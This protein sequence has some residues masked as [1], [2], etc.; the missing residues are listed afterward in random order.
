M[1]FAFNFNFIVA[2]FLREVDFGGI[3]D[4]S[5]AY[6]YKLI[7]E[8]MLKTNEYSVG[9]RVA[10]IE[11]DQTNEKAKVRNSNYDSFMKKYFFCQRILKLSTEQMKFQEII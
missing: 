3:Q 4:Y 11:S 5:D 7:Q 6:S 10:P 8:K 9:K 1:H 2:S